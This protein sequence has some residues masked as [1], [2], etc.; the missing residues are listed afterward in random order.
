MIYLAFF[1]ITLFV[2]ISFIAYIENDKIIIQILSI[3]HF[4]FAQRQLTQILFFEILNSISIA[5]LNDFYYCNYKRQRFSIFAQRAQ[6]SRFIFIL[7]VQNRKH[8]DWRF[9][10]NIFAQRVQNSRFIFISFVRDRKY[11]DWWFLINWKNFKLKEKIKKI[12]KKRNYKI[13]D[14]QFND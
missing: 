7:F 5:S 1:A 13:C 9:L 3:S 2:N 12:E 11:Y 8:Y 6:N 10:I 14:Y 4:S